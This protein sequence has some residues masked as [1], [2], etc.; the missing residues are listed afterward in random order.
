[1]E[2]HQHSYHENIYGK[3]NLSLSVLEDYVRLLY[4]NTTYYFIHRSMN[5]FLPWA[6]LERS[7]ARLPTGLKT[8]YVKERVT[9]LLRSSAIYHISLILDFIR[10]YAVTVLM[11][12][13]I[14][15]EYLLEWNQRLGWQVP[16]IK[17]TI[18]CLLPR[19]ALKS[20]DIRCSLI[21]KRMGSAR[22]TSPLITRFTIIPSLLSRTKCLF[23]VFCYGL[24]HFQDVTI[25]FTSSCPLVLW[26]HYL[27]VLVALSPMVLL[28]CNSQPGVA[29][30]L[31]IQ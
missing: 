8:K 24:V 12:Q 27:L 30:R 2:I 6:F 28:L 14:Q 16:R 19:R 25:S 21:W 3:F 10:V 7:V 18:M 9:L 26:W 4:L 22:F 11:T 17:S 5:L 1:M 13:H 31:C 23:L 15:T 20:E 29:L